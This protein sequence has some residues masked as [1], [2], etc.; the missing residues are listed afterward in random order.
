LTTDYHSHILP[1]IDDGSDSIKTSLKM[2]KMM[3]QQG[4]GIIVATP[5]FYIHREVSLDS[6]LVKRQNAYEKLMASDP[7]VKDIHI[8]AEVAIEKG[9]SVLGELEK[10]CISGTRLILL[11]PPFTQYNSWIVEEIDEIANSRR[12]I[13]IIAHVHRYMGVYSKSDLKSLMSVDAV[14]QINAEAFEHFSTR[15]FVNKLIS[16]GRDFVFGSDAHDL[17]DRKPNFDLIAKRSGSENIRRSDKVLMSAMA[18]EERMF[19]F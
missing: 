4:I 5:H 3:K 6:Y 13:P 16:S 2:I 19:A 18:D 7:A 8:G 1:N 15:R 10:L 12:L 17:D 11:E 9:I 14:F